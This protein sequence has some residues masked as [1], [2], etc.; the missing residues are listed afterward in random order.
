MVVVF[1]SLFATLSITVFLFYVLVQNGIIG[2]T[3]LIDLY[4]FVVAGL[5]GSLGT[6]VGMVYHYY[7]N[8]KVDD[9]AQQVI[10][11]LFDE[12]KDI[13]KES[14]TKG[15]DSFKKQANKQYK[16]VLTQKLTGDKK[17]KKKNQTNPTP[18]SYTHPRA[19]ETDH[20]L[21]CRLLLGK[22]NTK[23]QP[24]YKSKCK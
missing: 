13:D 22:K 17:K 23:K 11:R 8:K 24:T 2:Y 1:T 21:V 9:I 19:H 20:Y 16:E 18:L 10:V 6:F 5:V 12:K 4:K 15:F 14:V 7:K 3:H